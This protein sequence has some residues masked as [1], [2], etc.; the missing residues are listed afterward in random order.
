MLGGIGSDGLKNYQPQPN[1]TQGFKKKKCQ[2]TKTKG[3]GLGWVG[4]GQFQWVGEL[5][6]HPYSHPIEWIHKIYIVKEG[7]EW[8]DKLLLMTN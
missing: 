7:N 2:P 6:V 1:P 5:H 4:L 3:V 8:I